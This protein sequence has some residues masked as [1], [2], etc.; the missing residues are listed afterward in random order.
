M[1]NLL[2]TY[3]GHIDVRRKVN[4]KFEYFLDRKE[5]FVDVDSLRDISKIDTKIW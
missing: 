5:D 1:L 4:I 2:K 3:F